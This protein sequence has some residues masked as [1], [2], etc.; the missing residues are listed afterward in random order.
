MI[1]IKFISA[2]ET[3]QIRKE[4][5][6]KNIPLT[7]K[8]EGDFDDNT[9]HLGAFNDGNLISVATFMQNDSSYFNGNQYRLRGMATLEEFQG[10]GFGRRLILKAEVILNER[11]ATVLWCNARVVALNFYK[12]LGFKTIGTEFDIHHI[13]PHYVMF[14]KI[15]NA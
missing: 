4:I 9:F 8:T 6:R 5:L 10:K 2:E 13:G 14:K 1:E 15:I 12:K 7:E 11:K 3:Y